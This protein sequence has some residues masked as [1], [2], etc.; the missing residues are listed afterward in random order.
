MKNRSGI[1][2]SPPKTLY[3]ILCKCLFSEVT[4]QAVTELDNK[5][6]HCHSPVPQRHC[7]FL[8]GCL[9]R[10]PHYLFHGVIRREHLALTNNQSHS[11]RLFFHPITK[12]RRCRCHINTIAVICI[13]IVVRVVNLTNACIGGFK[14]INRASQCYGVISR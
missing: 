1:R 3:M 10:Q 5:S 12:H 7:P 6:A 13:S 4:V 8:R 11:T 9:D 2:A 14:H